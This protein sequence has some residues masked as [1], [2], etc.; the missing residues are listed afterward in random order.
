MK[1]TALL[2]AIFL[3][4]FSCKKEKQIIIEN[5]DIPLIS[6]VLIGGETYVWNIR[7]M[8]QI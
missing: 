1:K 7:I 6:K 2:I 3:T 8:K 4:L 5:T